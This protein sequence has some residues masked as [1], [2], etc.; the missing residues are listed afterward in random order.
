MGHGNGAD[1]GFHPVM[2]CNKRCE[3]AANSETDDRRD[4]AGQ[5]GDD[6]NHDV[7]RQDILLEFQDASMAPT[8]VRQRTL[9]AQGARRRQACLNKL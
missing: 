3:Q 8:R 9:R 4:S 7:E 6:P 5:Y 2:G 1:R